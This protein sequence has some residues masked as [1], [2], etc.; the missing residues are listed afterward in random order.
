MVRNSSFLNNILSSE[1]SQE[2]QIL[3]ET[4]K[5]YNAIIGC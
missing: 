2:E 3:D 5:A 4:N 1:F